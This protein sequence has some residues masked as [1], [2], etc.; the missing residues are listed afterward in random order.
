MSLDEKYKEYEDNRKI[1]IA[2]EKGEKSKYIG[3]NDSEK[4][5]AKINVILSISF[6]FESAKSANGAYRDWETDRKSVV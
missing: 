4:L 3:N 5:V 1:V 2:R 6:A